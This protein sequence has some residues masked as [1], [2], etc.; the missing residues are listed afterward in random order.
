[1]S[2]PY[3][4][5]LDLNLLR[6]F[7]V[8]AECGSVTEAAARLYLTQPAVSAALKRLSDTIRAPLFERSGRRLALNA[9]GTRLLETARPH[10]A[11]LLEA[12][13]AP[14]AVD[15]R[16]ADRK[17]RLG[18]S[19]SNEE[20]FLPPLLRALTRDAPRLR[21]VVTPV[22]FRTVGPAFASGAIDIAITVADDL[23]SGIVRTPL[24]AGGFVAVFDPKHTRLGRAPTLEHYLAQ[25][26]V[27]VSY[28]GDL[29]GAVEDL[30]GIARDVRVSIGSFHAV[31]AIVEGSPL[32]ATVPEIVARDVVRRRPR[33]RTARLP[34]SMA[35]ASMDLLHRRSQEDDG[36]H[37]L[38]RRHLV[39]IAARLRA[40]PRAPAR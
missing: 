22:Q 21:L 28:N 8:V 34:F 16:A 23:P 20:L 1:M 38:V 11:A 13:L 24:Y 15:L 25:P 37:A 35:G 39:T 7:L 36:A 33:L 40:R 27:V 30:L 17:I 29:R 32:V 12:T 3:A 18:L 2:A 14:T 19:D 31:G 26:H 5:D 10:L 4:R 6:V 9:R